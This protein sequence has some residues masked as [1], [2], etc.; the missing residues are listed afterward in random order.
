MIIPRAESFLTIADFKW[1]KESGERFVLAIAGRRAVWQAAPWT[2][3]SRVKGS[4]GRLGALPF[5]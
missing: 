1:A 5:L 3:W 4:L 2:K